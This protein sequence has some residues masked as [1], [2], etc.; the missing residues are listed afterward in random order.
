MDPGFP[1][2]GGVDPLGVPTYDFPKFQKKTA[3]SE[4]ILGCRGCA[5]GAPLDLRML[6][7]PYCPT[8][9]N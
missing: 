8:D 7:C 9:V 6:F 3:E 5:P 1:V 4:R 2:E